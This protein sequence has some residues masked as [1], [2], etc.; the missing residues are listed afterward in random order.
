[1]SAVGCCPRCFRQVSL[2]ESDDHSVWVRCPHCSEQY[3]LQTA[4]DFVPPALQIVPAPPLA[5]AEEHDGHET[6]AATAAFESESIFAPDGEH[7]EIAT[8]ADASPH[9][10]DHEHDGLAAHEHAIDDEFDSALSLDDAA[11]TDDDDQPFVAEQEHA[12]DEA[13]H[14]QEEDFRFADEHPDGEVAFGEPGEHSHETVG[15]DHALGAIATMAARPPKKK[16]H[17][18]LTVRL[19]GYGMFIASGVLGLVVVYGAS[20]YFGF[21]DPLKLGRHLPDWLVAKSLRGETDRNMVKPAPNPNSLRQAA[22]EPGGEMPK[23]PGPNDADASAEPKNPQAGD[24]KTASKPATADSGSPAPPDSDSKT[25]SKPAATDV[26]TEAPGKANPAESPFDQPPKPN[27][28][29]PPKDDA[30]KLDSTAGAPK[31]PSLDIPD[32]KISGKPSANKQPDNSSNPVPAGNAVRAS[33]TAEKPAETKV[34]KPTDK[35]LE[36]PTAEKLAK[37]IV[38]KSNVTYSLVDLSTAVDAATRSSAAL[39]EAAKTDDENALTAARRVNFKTMSHL[40]T[41]LTFVKSDAPDAPATIQREK[42]QVATSLTGPTAVS[43]VERK[44]VGDLAGKWVGYAKRTEA[45]IFAAGTLKAVESRGPFFESQVELPDGQTLTVVSSEKP[46][47]DDGHPVMLLG[48]IVN[49]PAKN[50][51]EYKGP[52]DPV[53]FGDLLVAPANTDAAQTSVGNASKKASDDLSRASK[54]GSP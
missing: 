9:G 38:P 36:G 27:D 51:P 12:M 7:A 34:E 17:V 35:P 26:A 29:E 5:A 53:I 10:E 22:D 42:D 4:I 52:A 30:S 8:G 46:A 21:S 18:P 3:S 25:V 40:A 49:D 48:A 1:M 11:T 50:L 54:P 41:V 45:G 14:D 32:L 23:Q 19:I 15:D 39:A 2:P 37:M 13:E 28:S 33:H 44:A 47:I 43:A 20:L 6:A 16:K 31:L 24:E